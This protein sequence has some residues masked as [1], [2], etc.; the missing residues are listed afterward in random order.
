MTG[1]APGAYLRGISDGTLEVATG[2]HASY[3]DRS[4]SG[5]SGALATG[6]LREAKWSP[7]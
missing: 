5:C 1:A 4:A 7:N 3:R 2:N 6:F